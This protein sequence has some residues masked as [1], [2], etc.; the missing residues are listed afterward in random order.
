MIFRCYSAYNLYLFFRKP[1]FEKSFF[2]KNV[3][4]RTLSEPLTRHSPKQPLHQKSSDSSDRT[5]FSLE[6]GNYPIVLKNTSNCSLT[7]QYICENSV[8]RSLSRHSS[9]GNI[10][11]NSDEKFKTNEVAAGKISGSSCICHRVANCKLNEPSYRMVLKK[12]HQF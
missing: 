9:Y 2:K 11:R 1:I 4:E 12:C 3:F 6:S 10:S 5:E 8:S 7:Q